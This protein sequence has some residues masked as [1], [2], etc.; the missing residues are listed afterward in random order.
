MKNGRELVIGVDLGATTVKTGL[1]RHDGQILYQNKFPT[2]AGEGPEAVVRQIVASVEEARPK[3]GEDPILGLGI[4]SPGVVDDHGVVKAPPNMKDWDEVPLAA[5]LGDVLGL[6]VAVENDANCAAIAESRFGAGRE[7]PNFLFVIWGTGVGGGII[8]DRKI[9]RGPTG[10]AGEIGHIVIDYNGLPCNCGSRGCVEA[11]IG[12]RYLSR[13]TAERL[14]EFP[15]SRILH[16]AANDP[17][18]IEPLHLSLAAQEGDPL[19]QE[20]LHE[21]GKLLGV[22]IGSV[23]NTMDLRVSIIGGGVSAV[24]DAV[25]EAMEQSVRDHVLK[26]LRSDIRVIRA[27]LGNDAGILGAAGLMMQDPG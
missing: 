22:A 12:Q 23:M 18:K 3:A 24:G 20:I 11:Y 8:L 1:V 26:P 16:H 6:P 13:R 4:G 7:H 21:A 15:S 10:G 9:F 17:T 19:A 5:I 25:F 2:R 27:Q 14:G